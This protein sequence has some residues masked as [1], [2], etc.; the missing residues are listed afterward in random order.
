MIH[1]MC[2]VNE[3]NIS[4]NWPWTTFSLWLPISL[5][6]SLCFRQHWNA[7]EIDVLSKL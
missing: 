1:K 4:V 2:L 7:W 6:D 5:Y 3:N